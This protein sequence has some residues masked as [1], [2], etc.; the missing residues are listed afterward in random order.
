M[1]SIIL[2]TATRYLLPLLMLFSVFI[3][4]RGHNDPGGGFIGG[5]VAAAAYSLYAVAYG[6]ERA[7]KL[8]IIAPRSL[9]GFGLLTALCSGLVALLVGKPFMTGLWA[10]WELPLIGK[11]GTPLFFDIGVYLV[12]IGVTLTIVFTLREEG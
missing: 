12:V 9:M 2:S 7:R 11:P 1:P 5:L 8:L 10:S 3:L 4:F 6:V